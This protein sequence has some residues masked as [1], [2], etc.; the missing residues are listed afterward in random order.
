MYRYV[1]LSVFAVLSMVTA[2]AK[3]FIAQTDTATAVLGIPWE[4][5]AEDPGILAFEPPR[6]YRVISEA[7]LRPAVFDR[8]YLLDTITALTPY[9]SDSLF[10]DAI[11]DWVDDAVWQQYIVR[12]IRQHYMISNP[13]KV[14]YNERLLPEPPRRWHMELDPQTAKLHFVE[15]VPRLPDS[16]A[17]PHDIVA[18][19]IGRRHWIRDAHAKLQFTQAY[20]SPNWYQGGSNNLTMLLDLGYSVKLNPSFHPKL[21][22]E[23]SVGYKLAIHGTPEDSL[24]NYNISEDLFQFNGKLGYKA[25]RNW[26][27]SMT[28]LVK[29][30]F[31]KNYEVNS[32]TLKA[33]FLSP[34]EI[35]MGIGMTWE[36]INPRK[37]FQINASLSPLS[38]NMKGCNYTRVNVSDYGI[39]P[40]HKAVHK[41]GSSG[42]LK[43]TWNITWNISYSSRLFVFTDFDVAQGDWENTV[44]FSINRFLSTQLYVHLRYDSGTP[45]PDKESN[46]HLWQLKEILSFGFA[47]QFS[48]P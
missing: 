17:A 3:R 12:R 7:D 26:F 6:E 43:F 40:G 10:R 30:Q 38:W 14:K 5:A 42:E 29:T 1:L 22:C 32:P 41:L 44:N 15:D 47:Y 18:G 23:M 20:V 46:W 28:A 8:Y 35:N 21:L 2:H 33:A 39:R 4:S 11:F 48:M 24:R 45:R 9:P 16:I 31:F 34:V 19:D 27:Y 13:G 25:W 37:T 36:H